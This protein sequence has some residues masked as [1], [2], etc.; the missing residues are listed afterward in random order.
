[1]IEETAI[2]VAHEPGLAW[3]ETPR[4]NACGTCGQGKDCGAALLGRLFTRGANQLAL[5]DHLGVASGERVVIGIP[6]A[7]LIR[8]ALLAYLLPLLTL[9]LGAAWAQWL[10]LEDIGVALMGIAGL[11]AGIWLTGHLTGGAQG[12]Q[13]YRPILLRR[14]PASA[15]GRG[16][17]V[18]APT[19][20]IH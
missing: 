14:E 20:T 2:V 11:G 4:R 18:S 13:R 3:V 19:R 10:R 7:L 1:M 15:P 17:P 9:V 6:D 12:R 8:A 5:E 16:V